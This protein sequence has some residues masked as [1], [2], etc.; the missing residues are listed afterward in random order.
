MHWAAISKALSS[1]LG[2]RCAPKGGKGGPDLSQM[3]R[4]PQGMMK[5]LQSVMDPRM[6]QQVSPLAMHAQLCAPVLACSSLI[7]ARLNVAAV[8]LVRALFC[9]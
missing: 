5:Q 3:Q 7:S 9:A 1:I 2:V 8:R 4:N 6:M